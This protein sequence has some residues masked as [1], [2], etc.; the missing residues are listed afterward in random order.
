MSKL[1][2]I[3]NA[4][5]S[6]ENYYEY[7]DTHGGARAI[8]SVYSI[9]RIK[10]NIFSIQL[11]KPIVNDNEIRMQLNATVPDTSIFCDIEKRYINGKH[12]SISESNLSS[13]ML[14]TSNELDCILQEISCRDICFVSDMKFLIENVKKWYENYGSKISTPPLPTTDSK[15]YFF[16]STES[17][18]QIKAVDNVL[19]SDISYVWG[20]PGTG[21]TQI[22]L[23]DCIRT[24][25]NKKQ[26]VLIIAPTNNAV[27]N[28]LRSLIESLQKQNENIDCLYRMG[29][30]TRGFSSAYGEICEHQDSLAIIRKLQ[31]ELTELQ[32]KRKAQVAAIN[33]IAEC[34]KFNCAKD[35]YYEALK[36][37]NEYLKRYEAFNFELSQANIQMDSFKKI[38]HNIEMRQEEIVNREKSVAFKA[39]KFFTDREAKLLIQESAMLRD[40]HN[41]CSAQALS[42]ENQIQAIKH[43]LS[44]CDNTIVTANQLMKA[45]QKNA[46]EAATKIIGQFYDL[47]EADLQITQIYETMKNVPFDENIDSKINAIN[48]QISN[49]NEKTEKNSKTRYVYAMTMDHLISHYKSLLDLGIFSSVSHIFLDE[50][51][52]CPLIKSAPLFSFNLPVT[53]LGDHMQLPPICEASETALSEFDNKLFLWDMSSIYFPQLFEANY[54]VEDIFELYINK[55][56]P[57]DNFMSIS[58]LTQTFRF[59]DNLAK[60]LDEFV[61]Q[62][63]FSGQTEFDTEITVIHAKK[64]GNEPQRRVN[65][66]EIKAIKEYLLDT[67][68]ENF[69]ILTPYTTQ[70]EQLINHL[71]G[72]VSYENISTI[73]A[74]QG[75]EWDTVIIS[76]SDSSNMYFTNSLIIDGLYTLNT[77]ISRAKKNLVIVC[78]CDFWGKYSNRQLIGRLVSNATERL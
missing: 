18:E 52:Y 22:V 19:S 58:I 78:N 31:Q 3:N 67:P 56:P 17:S 60:I 11:S 46:A 21:K 76:V 20:P 44:F 71:Q 16:S 73:H 45:E 29:M 48:Q 77:A 51:A 2:F 37:K 75:K 7:V 74:S 62:T 33:T 54:S 6:A 47:D 13:I 30:S 28:T 70:K 49:T 40:K 55:T 53:L 41:L 69:V 50:A 39:K 1:A 12:F 64:A 8:I 23:A 9:T 66:G 34:D 27:E 4:I 36:T 63:G 5:Q 65:Y 10:K 26:K 57:K 24:Y 35:K 25:I 43:S 32:E 59:G 72:I 14:K 15:D 42:L 68:L 61:Y 38:L